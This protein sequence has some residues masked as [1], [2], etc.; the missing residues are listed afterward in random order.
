LTKKGAKKVGTLLKIW[1]QWVSY[2]H[3]KTTGEDAKLTLLKG[4]LQFLRVVTTDVTQ[5]TTLPSACKGLSS[6]TIARLT[7]LLDELV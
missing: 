5:M 2:S 3:T 7:R 1:R 6:Y 4:F